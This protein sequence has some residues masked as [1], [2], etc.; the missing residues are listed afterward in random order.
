MESETDDSAE[1]HHP[2]ATVVMENA[3]NTSAMEVDGRLIEASDSSSNTPG[4]WNLQS[5][6]HVHTYI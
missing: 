3:T 6:A 1:S 2:N 4:I 5:C